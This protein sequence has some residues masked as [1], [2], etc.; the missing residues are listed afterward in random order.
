VAPGRRG[1]EWVKW[2]E[3]VEVLTAPD[4]GQVIAIFTSSL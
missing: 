2:L 3:R 4:L 1:F